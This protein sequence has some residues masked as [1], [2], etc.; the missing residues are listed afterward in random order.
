VEI[1]GFPTILFFPA[2]KKNE[3]PLKYEGPREINNFIDY[4]KEHSTKPFDVEKEAEAAA[5]E[6]EEEVKDEL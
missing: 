1:K 4:L 3:A 6:E 2:G 5:E